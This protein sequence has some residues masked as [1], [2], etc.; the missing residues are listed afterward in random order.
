MR[1]FL[2]CLI[3]GVL[4]LGLTGC[5]SNKPVAERI[6]GTFKTD[7]FSGELIMSLDENNEI[8]LFQ[9]GGEPSIAEYQITENDELNFV[10]DNTL[11]KVKFKNDDEFELET[12]N[13]T[14]TYARVDESYMETFFDN[15]SDEEKFLGYWE[16]FERGTR[17]YLYFDK[18]YGMKM[19][20]PGI[21]WSIGSYFPAA[22]IETVGLKIDKLNLNTK[23]GY[24]FTDR[25]HVT[26]GEWDCTR[27][28]QDSI[29]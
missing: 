12:S 9:T 23:V 14:S 24:R 29:K 21:D 5:G 20:S 3:C 18:T 7:T 28:S 4:C 16:F 13:G 15:L 22:N 17:F 11:F 6:I 1:K 19:S 2:T 10:G 8:E 27:I 25:N 26:I